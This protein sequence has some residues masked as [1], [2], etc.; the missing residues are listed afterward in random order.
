MIFGKDKETDFTA[1]FNIHKTDE[2]YYHAAM[3]TLVGCFDKVKHDDGVMTEDERRRVS[4]NP[5]SVELWSAGNDY[6]R[7][8]KLIPGS[9]YFFNYRKNDMT[10]SLFQPS[11]NAAG[12]FTK[13]FFDV[14]PIALI[15]DYKH[16]EY[17]DAIN[18]N[19]LPPK[20]RCAIL[21][22]IYSLDKSFYD[23]EFERKLSRSREY[24]VDE[25]AAVYLN[26][27]PMEFIGR[28]IKDFKMNEKGWAFRKYIDS[29]KLISGVHL[30]DFWKWEYI[31]FLDFKKGVEGIGIKKLQTDA[32]RKP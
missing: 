27:K 31:P 21:Q 25:K 28:T 11:S 12:V 18:L 4:S 23:Y 15:I 2:R 3:E 22:E 8:S 17:A 9:I 10:K 29:G 14:H 6:A 24:A 16:G 32:A 19:L 5:L 1:F 13:T 7:K 20:K 26:R 30:I